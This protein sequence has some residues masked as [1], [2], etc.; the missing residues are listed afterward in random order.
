MELA[1][2]ENIKIDSG[3]FEMLNFSE[4]SQ[5][6]VL[7]INGKFKFI[8]EV[9]NKDKKLLYKIISSNEFYEVGD[10]IYKAILCKNIYLFKKYEISGVKLLVGSIIQKTEETRL[11]LIDK[12]SDYLLQKSRT[13]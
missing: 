8:G 4:N 11:K 12:Q 6:I 1:A 3:V 10:K 9:S 7:S 13:W 5:L 2:L